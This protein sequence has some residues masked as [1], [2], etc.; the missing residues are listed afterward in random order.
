[1]LFAV[2][3]V[4]QTV[5]LF[6]IDLYPQARVVES[7]L[8]MVPMALLLPLGTWASRRMSAQAFKR[9]ILLLLLATACK[10]IY[11]AVTG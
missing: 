8:A 1:M 2:F 9:V 6:G 11:D 7:L 3:S 10:L 5:T 4:V